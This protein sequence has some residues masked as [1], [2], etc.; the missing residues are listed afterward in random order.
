MRSRLPWL[1]EYWQGIVL[2]FTACA[3]TLWLGAA[4]K[5]D[6][7]IHPRYILFTVVM[8][9]MALA[10]LLFG[11]WHG[12]GTRGL[13]ARTSLPGLLLG[14]TC[15]ILCLSLVVT[16][17]APLTSSIASQRG[18]NTASLDLSTSAT[19]VTSSISGSDYSRLTVKEWASLL[20]QTSD[21]GFF[22]GKK[23]QL[24]GFVTPIKEDSDSFYI[25]RFVVTCCAVD[26]RPIGVPVK[27]P[28]W[29]AVYKEN[30]WLQLKGEFIKNI[31]Q[32]S[33]AVVVD[34]ESIQK[35]NEPDNP[36]DF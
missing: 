19:D 35:I 5:L 7:Y 17:P 2:T 21:P 4:G 3:V 36:Y 12:Q 20:G 29:Q 15:M 8:G 1:S 6:L 25:S 23:V 18:V 10:I 28:G 13:T 22:V 27:M 11:M 33:P 30:Q 14:I 24:T 32:A 31:D 34:S 26:A 9:L 16:R